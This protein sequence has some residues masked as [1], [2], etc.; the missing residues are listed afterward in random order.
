MHRFSIENSFIP[1]HPQTL[2]NTLRTS[3]YAFFGIISTDPTPKNPSFPNI[4]EVVR[5]PPDHQKQQFSEL[6]AFSSVPVP[7]TEPPCREASPAT[8]RSNEEE[9]ASKHLLTDVLVTCRLTP[10]IFASPICPKFH[11]F[12]E[13]Y[14]T[15]K[16]HNSRHRP[17]CEVHL[18]PFD[19]A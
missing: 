15:L 9:D 1:K 19:R 10:P 11:I 18:S 4:P 16:P 7:E 14:P 2:P 12:F 8:R 6:R 3:K 5:T 17:N 13:K